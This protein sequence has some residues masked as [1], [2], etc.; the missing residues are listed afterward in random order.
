MG[1]SNILLENIETI[2]NN[3]KSCKTITPEVELKT[4]ELRKI[5]RSI[6]LGAEETIFFTIIFSFE[7]SE[8]NCTY[9]SISEYLSISEF[10]FFQ[11]RNSI[12]N[13]ID[14]GIVEKKFQ[15]S[16]FK[17]GNRYELRINQDLF[18][19]VVE[20]KPVPKSIIKKIESEI[21]W[22]ELIAL[23]IE[24]ESEFLDQNEINEAYHK[25]CLRFPMSK[26][27]LHLKNIN[28]PI[29]HSLLL[30]Y[31]IWENYLGNKFVSLDEIIEKI[32][33][34]RISKVREIRNLKEEKHPLLKHELIDLRPSK[35]VEGFEARISEKFRLNLKELEINIESLELSNS[36]CLKFDKIS[37]KALFFNELVSN[38]LN[39]IENLLDE[40][41]FKK[42]KERMKEKGMASGITAL[43]FGN[44]GTGKTESVFQLA[45]KY[46]RDVIHVDISETKSMWYGQ[47]EKLIKKIFTRYKE[48]LT[49][50]KNAPI[51]LLNEADAVLGKRKSGNKTKIDNT[52]NA[53]QNILLEEM[54]KFDGILIAT[55]NLV[56][57]LDSAFDR[58][59][60]FKVK[61][62]LPDSNQR[63]RI[64]NENINQIE[65]NLLRKLAD[66]F[67]FTGGQIQNIIRKIEINF[68]IHG[69]YPDYDKLRNLCQE[70]LVLS[71]SPK[72][73]IGFKYS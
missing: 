15:H 17:R 27:Q 57:N 8:K 67:T 72:S 3:L 43:F 64:W 32:Q 42:V 31:I 28:L 56:I 49:E 62:N 24:N 52:E 25:F 51:L 21:E 59:F 29:N 9:R 2:Y 13:L 61:F 46:K 16:H 14:K 55:T 6:H 35:F 39:T 36:D 34:T 11:F 44:P 22:I 12:N 30:I 47:S 19:L 54:E 5:M 69:C 33:S 40:K 60:L 63:F 7:L 38:Q 65:E 26:L 37:P 18:N 20:N 68:V 23:F 70:E 4:K 45:K 71:T 50:S 73:K 48:L 10:K 53:I 1:K 58:R 66:E 41:N